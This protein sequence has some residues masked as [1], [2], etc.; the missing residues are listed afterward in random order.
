MIG[1]CSLSCAA[2]HVHIGQRVIVDLHIVHIETQ[3]ESQLQAVSQQDVR[4]VKGGKGGLRRVEILGHSHLCTHGNPHTVDR[5]LGHLLRLLGRHTLPH[6]TAYHR[7]KHRVLHR[8]LNSRT[9]GARDGIAEVDWTICTQPLIAAKEATGVLP[10][11]IVVRA[12]Y[13]LLSQGVHLLALL[14]T[15][16]V[17]C[18]IVLVHIHPVLQE[19]VAGCRSKEQMR[20]FVADGESRIQ[21]V[22]L[23][24]VH[25]GR[26][27]ILSEFAIAEAILVDVLVIGRPVELQFLRR[28]EDQA[29]LGT[30]LIR[31]II[32]LV[33]VLIVDETLQPAIEA[34]HGEGQFLAGTMMVSHLDIRVQPR[35]N[36]QANICALIVHRVLGVDAHQSALGVLP[37]E[38]AL[39]ATQDVHTVEHIKMIVEGSLRHQGDIIVVD[40]HGGVV[41]A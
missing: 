19:L 3:A 40:T 32:L 35:A 36:A 1:G 20:H 17:G 11:R 37:V 29:H 24:A 34:S 9:N 31:E 12:Q 14:Q 6:K 18:H 27:G 5:T 16:V 38:R 23:V 10:T 39:R 25:E 15:Q 4:F 2:R 13:E 7:L 8:I 22:P 30:S 26:S 21:H 28:S 41:D 33:E